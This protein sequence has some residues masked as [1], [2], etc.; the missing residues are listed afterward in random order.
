MALT[1]KDWAALVALV[2]LF[3]SAFTAGVF[4]WASIATMLVALPAYIRLTD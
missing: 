2:A 1:A 3:G 4:G